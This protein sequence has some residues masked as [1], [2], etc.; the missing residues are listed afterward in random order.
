MTKI[1]MTTAT[2]LSGV[3]FAEFSSDTI[4]F[5]PFV[6]GESGSSGIDVVLQNAV[7]PGTL[8]AL[9]VQYNWAG[10][11]AKGVVDFDDDVPGEYIFDDIDADVPQALYQGPQSLHLTAEGANPG[12]FISF[13]DMATTL[14]GL[15]ECTIEFFWKIPADEAY[16]RYYSPAFLLDFGILDSESVTR[17]LG[18]ALPLGSDDNRRKQVAFYQC[19]KE[20]GTSIVPGGNLDDGTW[21]HVAVVYKNNAFSC[22]VDYGKGTSNPATLSGY[23]LSELAESKAVVFGQNDSGT[24]GF[25]GKVSCFRFS[26]KALAPERFLRASDYPHYKDI[27]VRDPDPIKMGDETIAFYSFKDGIGRVGESAAKTWFLND[28][29]YTQFIG[30]TSVSGSGTVTFDDDAPGAYV[31]TNFVIGATACCT[32]PMSVNFG[33]V[34]GNSA[35]IDLSGLA[36]ELSKLPESTIEFFWKLP[37]DGTESSWCDTMVWNTQMKDETGTARKFSLWVPY[38]AKTDANRGKQILFSR[39][40]NGGGDVCIK[41]YPDFPEDGKWHHVAVVFQNG[42][43]TLYNDYSSAGALPGTYSL[44][45]LTDSVPFK[46]GNGYYGGKISCLRVCRKALPVAEMLRASSIPTCKSDVIFRW[47]LNGTNGSVVSQIVNSAPT[48]SMLNPGIYQP[49]SES[50]EDGVVRSIA[51]A[52]MLFSDRKWRFDVLEIAGGDR[53]ANLGSVRLNP[54][55]YDVAMG[56][57]TDASSMKSQTSQLQHGSMTMEMFAKLNYSDYKTR[58]ADKLVNKS[59]DRVSLMMHERKGSSAWSLYAS[60]LTS[61]PELVLLGVLANGEVAAATVS[62]DATFMA[63]WHHYAVVYDALN[64]KL[65]LWVDY[66]RLLEKSLSAPLDYS[67]ETAYHLGNGGSNQPFDGL[68]DEVRLTARVLSSGEFLRQEGAP[69]MTVIVR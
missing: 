5:Y 65:E 21:H 66:A 59:Y 42:V 19:G 52:D 43:F 28:I 24:S 17:R 38:V 47:R 33:R 2:L 14:S 55:T 10:D 44:S 40:S 58:I 54:L 60:A 51:G 34:G 29:D 69:G 15:D 18:V 3:A 48:Y 32:N 36:T 23:S 20:W 26:K 8:D 30:K 49:T 4:G 27:D 37:T 41:S 56:S 53:T 62:V 12:G 67:Q 45:E 7:D 39:A 46:L 11:T 63:K 68:I 22:Y 35:N 25:H 50:V 64:L 57:L 31:F 61:A 13:A 16:K 9:G 6:E 1:L